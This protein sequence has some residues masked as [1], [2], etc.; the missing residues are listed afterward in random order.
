MELRPE[1]MPP[2]LGEAKV[3]RLAELASG[4][5]GAN[6]GLWEEDLA[7]FNRVAGTALPIEDFQG[8]YGAE[9]HE[10]WVRRV[11]VRQAVRPVADV[12]RS[13][14]VEII[15]RA[16]PQNGYAD[17]E[18]YM[19][20]FDANV[21]LPGASNLIF[22]PMDYDPATNTWGGGRQMGEYDP[23][24]EQIGEWALARGGSEDRA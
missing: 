4:L 11:L 8:I 18:A 6:P 17:H 10:A 12:T 2:A 9:E 20:V 1:L 22:Y 16:M 13:D 19:A 23:T 5:D 14:L 3:R 15:R 24:P 21:P 7:E